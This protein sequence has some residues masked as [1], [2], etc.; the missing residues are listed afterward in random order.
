[1]LVERERKHAKF[2]FVGVGTQ[3]QEQGLFGDDFD[4]ANSST[5]YKEYKVWWMC[6][7][8]FAHENSRMTFDFVYFKNGQFFRI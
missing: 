5:R 3:N 1:M 8:P 2:S 6:E 7:T 4:T